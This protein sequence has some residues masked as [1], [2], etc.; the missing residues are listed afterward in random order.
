M[1]IEQVRVEPW[2]TNLKMMNFLAC[3]AARKRDQSTVAKTKTSKELLEDHGI[4]VSSCAR[5]NVADEIRDAH[6]AI[7]LMSRLD[8]SILCKAGELKLI[9][10]FGVGLEGVDVDAATRAKIP[11][12]NI[13]SEGTG[14]A[15]SCAEHAI[16][17]ML[18][19]LR[20]QSGMHASVEKQLLGQPA[21]RVLLG[22]NVLLVGYGGIGKE[23]APRLAPFGVTLSAVRKSPWPTGDDVEKCGTL[24][25]KGGPDDLPEMLSK[26]D[27]VVLTCVLN[28]STRGMV[29][30]EFLSALKPGAWLV[31]VAR[32]P[33]MDYDAV[34]RALDNGQLAGVATD[35]TWTEPI[36]P[37]DQFA[38]HPK[39]IVTPHIAGVTNL[40]YET[41]A[42]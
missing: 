20:D 19:L 23:L 40:S 3:V 7:P 27:I 4:Q 28:E 5:E 36:N 8:E 2:K 38:A 13:R 32:G 17:L 30:D 33:L 11:V 29:N 31:N 16:Y 18:A 15:A 22:S 41:M 35:V 25:H 21:G 42:K 24:S 34:L 1:R 6:V 39:V 9:I 10:Q 37:T 14:N 12:S 26:T